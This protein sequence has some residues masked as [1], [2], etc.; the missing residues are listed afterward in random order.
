AGRSQNGPSRHLNT[1]FHIIHLPCKCLENAPQAAFWPNIYPQILLTSR[2]KRAKLKE[3][4]LK[5]IEVFEFQQA[6]G[7]GT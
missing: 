6:L 3:L 5:N 7:S 1:E 4:V 2:Q